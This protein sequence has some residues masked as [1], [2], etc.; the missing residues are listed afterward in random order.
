MPSSS[1]ANTTPDA[2][3]IGASTHSSFGTGD[4]RL[5]EQ[6]PVRPRFDRYGPHYLPF[7]AEQVPT[8]FV[9]DV[10]RSLSEELLSAVRETAILTNDHLDDRIREV[11]P[12][13]DCP[14][15]SHV[16]VVSFDDVD[17]VLEVPAHGLVW[18]VTNSELFASLLNCEPPDE[19]PSEFDAPAPFV[20]LPTF[21]LHVP[22]KSAWLALHDFVYLGSASRLLE[23]LVPPASAGHGEESTRALT[24][25]RELWINA[26]ALRFRDEELWDTIEEAWA[27]LLRRR[28]EEPEDQ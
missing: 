16:L 18:A 22:Y 14:I 26:A 19:D 6:I 23:T 13:S 10:L 12:P 8:A 3:S 17:E 28:R 15:P 21:P 11:L 7:D 2:R 9:R 4:A 20:A 27:R 1:L 24:R 25:V 5:W